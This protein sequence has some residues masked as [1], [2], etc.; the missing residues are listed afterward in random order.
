M[1]GF[2]FPQKRNSNAYK[3][4][5]CITHNGRNMF[6]LATYISLGAKNATKEEAIKRMLQTAGI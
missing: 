2:L 5:R 4:P 3:N 1:C 6:Y